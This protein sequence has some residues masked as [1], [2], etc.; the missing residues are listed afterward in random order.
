MSKNKRRARRSFT[1]DFKAEA[2]ALVESSG[3]SVGRVAGDLDLSETALRQWV[4][5]AAAS[6]DANALPQLNA[7]ERAELKHLRE[8]NRVLRMERDFL[9]KAAAFFAKESK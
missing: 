4:S 1:D 5:K 7:G 9:K 6:R 3:K 2:V 8:D